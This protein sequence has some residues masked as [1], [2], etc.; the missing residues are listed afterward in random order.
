MTW[1][2]LYVGVGIPAILVLM[3]LALTWFTGRADRNRDESRETLRE[4]PAG[5]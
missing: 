2:L 1:H 5:H 4:R 3:G